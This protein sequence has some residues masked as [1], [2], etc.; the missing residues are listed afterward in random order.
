MIL[1][2]TNTESPGK[3]IVPLLLSR[4]ISAVVQEDAGRQGDASKRLE[5][6]EPPLP[7]MGIQLSEA[8]KAKNFSSKDQMTD[9]GAQ[10]LAVIG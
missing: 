5:T 3:H 7:Y 8:M 6:L 1:Q 9:N 4:W 2:N 10:T